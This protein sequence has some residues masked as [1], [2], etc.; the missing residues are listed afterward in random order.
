MSQS[1]V[2][3][4]TVATELPTYWRIT[5]L[6]RFDGNIWS[7]LSNYRPAGTRSPSTTR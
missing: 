1:S 4:F 6:D 2:E 7:S 3:L 5:S